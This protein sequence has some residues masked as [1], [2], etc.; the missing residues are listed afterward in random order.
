MKRQVFWHGGHACNGAAHAC[1]QI[2]AGYGIDLIRTWGF[3][4]GAQDALAK[5]VALQPSVSI[6]HPPPTLHAVRRAKQ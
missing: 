2:M 5:G 1:V 3:L 6:L 4:N